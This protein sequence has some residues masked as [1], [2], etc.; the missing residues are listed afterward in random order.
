VTD[1]K[2]RLLAEF[3][4]TGL[5]VAVVVGS[6]IAAQTLSTDIGLELL[7]NALVTAAGLAVLILVFGPISGAHFNP[8][9]SIADWAL[10]RRTSTGLSGSELAG[11]VVAQTAG[12]ISGA[13]L[14]NA[15]FAKPLVSWSQHHRAQPHL[16]LGEVVA[17]AGLLLVIVA[18]ARN[19]KSTQTP[20]AVGA[21]IG[22]AY[23]FTSS[24]SFANPA[25]SI[26]RAFTNTFAGIA[27]VSLP[28]FIVA[29]LVGGAVGLGLLALLYPTADEIADDLLVP[30]D[31]TADHTPA[32][33]TTS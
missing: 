10:G 33:E 12:A 22:A 5:L 20:W 32:M 4:G 14:A 8:V 7:E 31:P 29:Q 9:V 27:P 24:T 13:I 25:V 26:G 17:T 16:L 2:R 15:M 28:G 6:G 3:L 23:F 18:L 19:G 11:Y 1:A 30:H 21:Y